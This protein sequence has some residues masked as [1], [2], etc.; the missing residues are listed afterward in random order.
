MPRND[1]F[2]SSHALS[3]H[4]VRSEALEIPSWAGISRLDTA[5][6][7]FT[8]SAVDVRKG[9]EAGCGGCEVLKK[10]L[11]GIAPL[12]SEAEE[13]NKMNQGDSILWF[14]NEMIELKVVFCAGQ[15]LRVYVDEM[16]N[17]KDEDEDGALGGPLYEPPRFVERYL[18]M[19]E[20]YCL[21]GMKCCPWTTIGSSMTLED[22]YLDSEPWEG[23]PVQHVPENPRL[24]AGIKMIR[25][26]VADCNEQ[27]GDC[28]NVASLSDDFT[29]PKRVLDVGEDENSIRL[30]EL[31]NAYANKAIS[32]QDT[33]YIA[34]SH[35][36]GQSQHLVTTTVTL[37]QRKQSISWESLPKTFQD[38]ILITRILGLKYIWIDSLCIIQDSLQDWEMEAAKM[39]DIYNNAYLVISATGSVD[40]DGGCFF[41]R[42]GYTKID[43][44]DNES[45]SAQIYVRRWKSHAP[46]GWNTPL[47][48]TGMWRANRAGW[49]T[50]TSGEYPLFS[51][52]WCFQERMLGTRVLHFAKGEMVF[53]CLAAMQ[54]ECGSM[55]DYVG[56]PLLHSR[57]I[58]R[59][60][61]TG[62]ARA[63]GGY[64]SDDLFAIWGDIVVE[65]SRK[66]ITYAT[67]MFPA[68][69]GIARK[70]STLVGGRYLAGIWS[71]DIL[72]GLLWKSTEPDPEHDNDT[73]LAP[74]WSWANIRRGIDWIPGGQATK[75]YIEIDLA[76]TQ[77]IHH[78]FN[79]FGRL[80]DGALF[81]KGPVVTGTLIS[82]DKNT[83][84]EP[85]GYVKT[86]GL[87]TTSF[88]VDN[89]RRCER[90]M[91]GEVLVLRYCTDVLDEKTGR[92]FG[93]ALILGSVPEEVVT[94][95]LEDV[96][97]WNGGVYE[98]LGITEYWS[99]DDWSGET[100]EDR[101][102]YII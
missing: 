54:C 36:W 45:A 23:G 87:W 72:R 52:A 50:D 73:Y 62:S 35:C 92:G 89:V 26:W 22:P 3:R 75:Y 99:G 43:V 17:G 101:S 5:A 71:S 57:G 58:L 82:I 96:R 86:V 39:G 85:T 11:E 38:S 48:K 100:M 95:R 13:R 32:L 90:R 66:R 6:W 27:H 20:F 81:L 68:L 42:P 97:K 7:Q 24:D 67:D 102:L 70:W 83:D 91:D 40:G 49:R 98:R 46:F 51:R 53:E 64:G 16:K 8:A 80:K 60:A 65:Y 34:L 47:R 44:K 79:H 18:G 76:K 37:G 84:R 41:H 31:E 4:D 21:P 12:H 94:K 59:Y 30:L 55:S 88:A 63:A 9:A 74:S 10:G 2:V 61:R 29:L 14:E 69:A 56:D 33:S 28:K 1:I 93:R 25:R 15:V 77:C 19:F 78:G